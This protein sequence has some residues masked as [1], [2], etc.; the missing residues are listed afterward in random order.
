MKVVPVT[1]FIMAV[2]HVVMGFLGKIPVICVVIT[3]LFIMFFYEIMHFA[4]ETSKK[5]NDF[6]IIAGY[7]PTDSKITTIR[8]LSAIDLICGIGAILCEAIFVITYYDER[9]MFVSLVI[10]GIY[11]SIAIIANVV[12]KIKYSS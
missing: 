2:A 6:T 7:K 5:N 1:V 11:I 9:K 3:P 8:K 4:F 10:S 12:V